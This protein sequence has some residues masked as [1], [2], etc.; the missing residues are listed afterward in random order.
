MENDKC[1]LAPTGV[2]LMND[3]EWLF[4]CQPSDNALMY[5]VTAYTV[6]LSAGNFEDH[7]DFPV[8]IRSLYRLVLLGSPGMQK[9]INAHASP[10]L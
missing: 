7:R 9:L 3:Y 2:V 6:L 5:V 10:A 8:L 4:A 1:M